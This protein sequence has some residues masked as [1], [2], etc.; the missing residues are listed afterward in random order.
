MIISAF[1]FVLI[2]I[3]VCHEGRQECISVNSLN[4][5]VF[6]VCLNANELSSA[7]I[8]LTELQYMSIYICIYISQ[9]GKETTS[10]DSLNLNAF[11]THF[12]NKMKG[13]LA[14]GM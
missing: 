10:S 4:C 12:W 1:A 3:V 6:I 11:V 2:Q 14:V 5:I 9:I 8:H 7:K 13:F